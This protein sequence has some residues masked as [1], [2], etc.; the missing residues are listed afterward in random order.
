MNKNHKSLE[1]DKILVLLSKHTSCEDALELALGLTPSKDIETV[2]K[3]LCET[4]DA[5]M[6]IARF[7]AP[8]FY[9][10]KNCNNSLKRAES[11][12]I[13]SPGEL[14]SIASLL[15]VFQSL[16]DWREHSA[17]I[18]TVLND[19]FESIYTNKYLLDKITQAIISEEEISDHASPTLY[20]IRRK[21]ASAQ[22]RV[23]DRLEKIIKSPSHQKNLQDAI[24]TIRDGRFVVPVKQ[25]MRS[26][27]PGLVHDTSSSGQTVFVE[28]ME[29][30][31]A[32]NEIKVLKS[33]EK[34]EIERILAELSSEA[35]DYATQ[36]ITSF[37]LCVGLNLI[38]AKAKLGFDMDAVI[39]EIT[40]NGITDLKKARHPLLDKH[41][42]VPTDIYIGKD[43]DT[44]IITGPNTGGKTVSIKTLGLL[45][46]MAQCGLMVSASSESSIS[47]FDE[48]LCDIGDEQSI[49]Q[50]LSTF[51]AHMTNIISIMKKVT[52]RSLILLDELGAGTDPV[53][54][55]ALAIAILERLQ[56]MGA[57]TVATTHYA[58]LKAYALRTA[59]VENGSCEFNVDTLSPTYRLL[60]GIPG[61]SN[62]FAILDRL[63]MDPSVVD[64]ARRIV[65]EQSTVF[66]DV[67]DKLEKKR[68]ELETEQK[69]A[70]RVRIDAEK[71]A[72]A[73][74][75]KTER[76]EAQK[77]KEYERAK[78]EARRLV[79]KTRAEV[80]RLLTE[81]EELKKQA[82]K[83]NA[84]EM[85]SKARA[86][87][88]KG[89]DS[90]EGEANPVREKRNDGYVLPRKLK[91]GDTVLIV[92][93]DKKA[94]VTKIP[95]G[96][97]TVFVQEGIINTQVKINN[98]RLIENEKKVNIP[99]QK[100]INRG[101][102]ARVLQNVSTTLDIRGKMVDEALP[103]VDLFLDNAVICKLET[104]TIIHG[105]GTGALRNGVRTHLRKHRC[106]K[107][108]RPGMYGEGEDGVTI[109]TMK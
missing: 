6:L 40:D 58:E 97:D 23:R 68:T 54:G 22:N 80:N 13:L 31:E 9:G 12:G 1:L 87:A 66:E 82:N 49:E 77:E 98:L 64:R 35:G 25:E 39:P 93:I 86:A 48:I 5:H 29:V 70:A 106:V 79:D 101:V 59:R 74:E 95:D 62:A 73:A 51:S 3:L 8:S 17:D 45:T 18:P 83:E 19:G 81:L 67:I 41:K 32:N 15:R 30:V 107:A 61:R 91:V 24:V 109:V 43:F 71:K 89:M 105:K 27:L 96:K 65:P 103:E 102:D 21:I 37:E 4:G 92:D 16:I 44:L 53:E 104:V 85:L 56:L 75:E 72:K 84:A 99:A 108:F 11:G 57:K 76:F 52:D 33:K 100:S 10:L 46:L 55:A 28:P 42:V 7:G 60:I 63:G 20:D 47:V 26:A 50:S 38:F 69:E 34:A 78:E 88:K 94:T 36:I 2:K 14:M 90:A